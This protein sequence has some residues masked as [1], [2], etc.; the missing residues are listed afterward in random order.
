VTTHAAGLG[1]RQD[2]MDERT[3]PALELIDICKEFDGRPALHLASFSVEWGEVHALLGENGAGKSTLM[4]IA[5][6]LYAPDSGRICVD[7]RQ[8]AISQPS[9]AIGLGIGMVH[10]HFK[11]VHRF[12]VAENIAL[13]YRGGPDWDDRKDLS[14][15]IQKK[16]KE[17]GL[18]VDP[19]AVVEELSVAEQQRVEILKAL[20]VGAKILVLDEPTAVLT[21]HE[22]GTILSLVKGLTET[23]MAVVLI[24]HKLK[25]VMAYSDRVTVMRDGQTTMPGT[26][27][28]TLV[29][30]DIAIAMVG[31][32]IDQSTRHGRSPSQDVLL[33]V[34]GLS[35]ANPSGG[36]GAE[37][38]TFRVQAG[39][40]F[41]I[42]GVGGNGQAQLF[43][44]L[45]GSVRPDRGR[46]AVTGED[47][48]G[49]SVLSF[50]D[51]GM[52]FI[53]ADRFATGLIS[54]LR[55][56]ENA[57]LP[58]VVNGTYGGWWLI[59]RRQMRKYCE[60]AISTHHILG[61]R[62]DT[63]TRLLSGGNAQKLLLSRELE[64]GVR[65]VVA[66]SPTRGLDL[67][68]CDAVHKALTAIADS[69]AACVLISEDLD[70]I[71]AL[72]DRIAVMSKGRFAGEFAAHSVS[73][74]AIGEL[75]L[76]HA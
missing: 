67:E 4:N 26:A 65:V 74:E 50:R 35:A 45:T 63:R 41:G 56:Y 62:P 13:V 54:E 72:S 3:L 44:A 68:A 20:L 52:R 38:I 21:D 29:R 14:A 27:T 71:L 55:A 59:N 11:L 31:K 16:S 43:D 5:A 58:D 30:E 25:E 8:V 6:G 76:G 60:A 73:R 32:S 28:S 22:S 53:P 36:I 12:T 49:E 70:E 42:A 46:I 57:T 1:D 40:I 37:D 24:T 23:G 69:G 9:H 2:S 64:S 33:A 10:Q 61:C 66:H 39:E 19:N 75:M 18:A 7:G 48:T 15:L 51:H 47:L 34:D 17:V